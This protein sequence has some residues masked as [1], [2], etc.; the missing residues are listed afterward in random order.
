MPRAS[1]SRPTK[2]F[3]I[4]VGSLVIIEIGE[5]LLPGVGGTMVDVELV[6]DS[7]ADLVLHGL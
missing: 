3:G 7:Q 6:T 5:I 1:M 4:T 2:A